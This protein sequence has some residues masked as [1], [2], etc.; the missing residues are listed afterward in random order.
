MS[1]DLSPNNS[2]PGSPT[3]LLMS[4]TTTDNEEER[5]RDEGEVS[6]NLILGIS[7]NIRYHE[8]GL[9]YVF[10]K[11]KEL[12]PPSYEQLGA[13]NIFSEQS[14]FAQKEDSPKGLITEPPKISIGSAELNSSEAMSLQDILKL[15]AQMEATHAAQLKAIQDNFALQQKQF[16]EAMQQQQIENKDIQEQLRKVQ[17]EGRSS[18]GVADRGRVL[19]SSGKEEIGASGGGGADGFG[20]L[21]P[22]NP[23]FTDGTGAE[24]ENR[25]SR[26]LP[27]HPGHPPPKLEGTGESSTG[28]AVDRL[29]AVLE[30]QLT[31]P[32]HSTRLPSLTLPKLIKSS[33]NQIVGT[34]FFSFKKRCLQLFAEHSVGESIAVH[35]LQTEVSL[36]QRFRESLNN[37]STIQGCFQTMESMTEPLTA[38]YPQLLKELC[39]VE[40]AFDNAAQ[41][42]LCDNV[43]R[44]LL[45]MFEHFPGE[46]IQIAHVTAVISAFSSQHEINTLPGVV[47][48]F[49]HKH[50]TTH[51]KFST[52]LYNHC[53]QRR[54]DLY[55][56]MAALQMWR[57]DDSIY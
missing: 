10:P 57:K 16:S 15:L 17:E 39:S 19:G 38:V 24:M 52:L 9:D 33:N 49:Q 28:N 25:I 30:K 42:K 1:T 27:T 18:V 29:V 34:D 21:F 4:V 13:T 47:A 53:I 31:A 48:S 14:Q 40:S 2:A 8:M 37:C 23:S 26:P 32:K 55:S 12:S 54:T 44:I 22:F 45:Q 56:I 36:P 7:Y 11:A 3:P 6:E 46:D 43:C 20:N 50:S 5:T 35:L 51:Q 41:I